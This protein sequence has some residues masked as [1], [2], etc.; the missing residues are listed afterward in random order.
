MTSKDTTAVCSYKPE[1]TNQGTYIAA[2]LGTLWLAWRDDR[3]IS[4][5]F[6]DAGEETCDDRASHDLV[7]EPLRRPLDAYFAGEMSDPAKVPV[8]LH[9]TAFQVRVWQ[10]LRQIPRGSVRSYG[11]IAADLG[12]P[13]AMR[14]VGAANSKNPLPIVVPC[15]RVVQQGLRLGGYTGGLER[16]R[17]LLR[18]EGV[19]VEGDRVHPGQLM[20]DSASRGGARPA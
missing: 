11:G 3:L 4:L 16:K 6:L 18:L 10:A 20:L 8:L 1:P 14:A 19:Q 17:L 9:G 13:R 2:G 12:A 15:H 5:E 7:P